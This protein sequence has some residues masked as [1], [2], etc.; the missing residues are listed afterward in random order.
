MVDPQRCMRLNERRQAE[1]A[2]ALSEEHVRR[3]PGVLAFSAG[4][5]WLCKAVGLDLDAPLD[6]EAVREVVAYYRARRVPPV[7]ELSAYSAEGTFAALARAGFVLVE[8][9]HVLAC[10]PHTPS[11]QLPP[12]VQLARLDGADDEAVR[13]H[14]AVVTC[15][16]L[17]GGERA[18]EPMLAVAVRALRQPDTIGLFARLADGTPVGASS[19]EIRAVDL[20]D[21]SPP[22]RA[23]ALFGTTVVPEARCQGIQQ[24]FIAERL[25]LGAEAGCALALVESKPGIPT[26]RNAARLGFAPS[27]TRLVLRAPA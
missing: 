19:M 2:A 1:G 15:G 26:E 10:T 12:G 13:E 5:P 17:P 16:F 24:A 18:P 3:G 25:R 6:D 7:V 14:A 11:V 9:E 27:Y 4:T 21:G 23:L 22:V 20:G 8:T